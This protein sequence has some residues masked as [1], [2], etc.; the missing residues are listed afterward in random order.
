MARTLSR[1]E[2][3]VIHG[4]VLVNLCGDTVLMAKITKYIR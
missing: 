3:K 4:W 2:S 1:V